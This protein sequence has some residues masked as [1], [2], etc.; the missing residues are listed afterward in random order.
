MRNRVILRRKATPSCRL[1]QPRSTATTTRHD[2]ESAAAA[3]GDLE[4]VAEADVAAL[5]GEAAGRMGEIPEVAEG[6]PLHELEQ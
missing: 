3:G 2:A 4:A 1:I 6:L 5:V